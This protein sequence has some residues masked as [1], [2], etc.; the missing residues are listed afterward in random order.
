MDKCKVMHMRYNNSQ[1]EYVTDGSKLE[2]VNKE[3][4][5]GVIIS[6]NLKYGKTMQCRRV[7]QDCITQEIHTSLPYRDAVKN[8]WM[9]PWMTDGVVIIRETCVQ[10]LVTVL[11]VVSSC[12]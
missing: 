12:W 9:T 3:K 2:T 7:V 4:D 8:S 10:C 11:D 5:L 1:A 6:E